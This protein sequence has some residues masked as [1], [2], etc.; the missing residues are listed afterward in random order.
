MPDEV[1]A[2]RFGAPGAIFPED[3]FDSNRLIMAK[4]L[5]RLRICPW[6]ISARLTA[7]RMNTQQINFVFASASPYSYLQRLDSISSMKKY[8]FRN[9]R[10]S[11]RVFRPYGIS[12]AFY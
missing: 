11:L 9:S 4:I 5:F 1:T 6:T 10:D 12:L 7:V 2:A 8:S 3:S